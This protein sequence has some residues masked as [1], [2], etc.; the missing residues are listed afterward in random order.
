MVD[1]IHTCIECLLWADNA[2]ASL[3]KRDFPV[4]RQSL[5]NELWIHVQNFYKSI[6]GEL[7]Y[8]A[9]YVEALGVLEKRSVSR[10][11]DVEMELK[12]LK[13]ENIIDNARFQDMQN[14]SQAKI[15]SKDKMIYALSIKLEPLCVVR[16]MFAKCTIVSRICFK[17]VR[18]KTRFFIV[19]SQNSSCGLQCGFFTQSKKSVTIE[20]TGF[21][22]FW[23][24]WGELNPRP[25]AL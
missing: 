12:S 5:A 16:S 18:T 17:F 3:R 14:L 19:N 11:I 7:S 2:T 1:E 13:D 22:M 25:K 9:Q 8:I 20:I 15:K 21:L 4:T 6:N 23:W 10:P 24:R